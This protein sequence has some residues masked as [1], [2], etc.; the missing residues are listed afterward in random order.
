[1]L[2][3]NGV[4]FN[5]INRSFPKLIYQTVNA[6]IEQCWWQP[7]SNSHGDRKLGCVS[8]IE[9]NTAF[10]SIGLFYQWHYLSEMPRCSIR[11][12]KLAWC[13]DS[14]AGWKS[15]KSAHMIMKFSQLLKNL[16]QGKE[17]IDRGMT[18]SK[19]TLRILAFAMKCIIDLKHYHGS[20]DFP[21]N[22]Q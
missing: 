8:A 3:Q 5:A 21:R 9:S 2:K 16:S 12:H 10:R 11:S 4:Q 17:L 13:T 1:M 20:E 14:K 7:V 15:M 18:R 22:R 6:N 19:N